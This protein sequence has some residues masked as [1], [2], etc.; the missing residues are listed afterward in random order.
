MPLFRSQRNHQH[1][2]DVSPAGLRVGVS[3]RPKVRSIAVGSEEIDRAGQEPH[4]VASAA[5]REIDERAGED[6]PR[7][8]ERYP[9]ARTKAGGTELTGAMMNEERKSPLCAAHLTNYLLFM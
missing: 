4:Y 9:E 1:R 3:R 5:G 2:G 7:D 8:G 6:V